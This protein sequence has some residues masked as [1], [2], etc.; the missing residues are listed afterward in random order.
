VSKLK[1][2]FVELD[3]KPAAI[4]FGVKRVLAILAS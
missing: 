4:I 2:V 1:T 3:V